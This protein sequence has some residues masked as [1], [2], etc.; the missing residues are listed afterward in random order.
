MIYTRKT[1]RL[2]AIVKADG[3]CDTLQRQEC[4]PMSPSCFLR[5]I[6]FLSPKELISPFLD[7]AVNAQCIQTLKVFLLPQ[8]LSPPCLVNLDQKPRQVLSITAALRRRWQS[9]SISSCPLGFHKLFP[10]WLSVACSFCPFLE[11]GFGGTQS[12]WVVG[13]PLLLPKWGEGRGRSSSF[14]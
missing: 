5:N 8:L 2:L 1:L 11:H 9:P 4:V 12:R 3:I 14:I 7:L 13:V 6:K 10:I